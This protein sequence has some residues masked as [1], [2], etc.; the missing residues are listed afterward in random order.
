MTQLQGIPRAAGSHY[1][2]GQTWTRVSFS[3]PEGT[4]PANTLSSDFCPLELCDDEFLLFTPPVCR[5]FLWQPWEMNLNP[6]SQVIL[7]HPVVHSR[8]SLSIRSVS[9]TQSE[10]AR[11]YTSSNKLQMVTFV[12]TKSDKHLAPRS[13]VL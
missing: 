9:S 4:K 3:A 10:P 5:R 11:G 13:V 2:I 8:T 7:M 1:E 6:H 12:H